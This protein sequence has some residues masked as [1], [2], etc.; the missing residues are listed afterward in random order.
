MWGKGLRMKYSNRPVSLTV[1][2]TPFLSRGAGHDPLGEVLLPYS[3]LGPYASPGLQVTISC[4]R[5]LV[6]PPQGNPHVILMVVPL[7]TIYGNKIGLKYVYSTFLECS[8]MTGVFYH[9]V[10]RGLGFFICFKI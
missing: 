9:I 8:Q 1:S 2:L 10:I 7:T 4:E 5:S 6:N 3:S